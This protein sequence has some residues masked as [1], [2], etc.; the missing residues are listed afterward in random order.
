M[1]FSTETKNELSRVISDSLCCKKAELS[2]IAKLAGSIQIVGYK[3]I[4]LKISTELNSVARKV[5]KILKSDFNIN[6]NIVVNKNQMLKRNNNIYKLLFQTIYIL[7][8]Y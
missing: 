6:T 4:N 7:I 8:I 5:F 1:S 3:K 2:G